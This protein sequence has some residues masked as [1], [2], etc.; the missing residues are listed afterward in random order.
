MNCLIYNV[1]CD[2]SMSWSSQHKTARRK[3]D[4]AS[5]LTPP[6]TTSAESRSFVEIENNGDQGNPSTPEQS[7]PARSTFGN[8]RI[9]STIKS[10]HLPH[11]IP[12]HLDCQQSNR[13]VT[14]EDVAG[15]NVP[16]SNPEGLVSVDL[17]TGDA[18]D[19]GSVIFARAIHP[20]YS[21]GQ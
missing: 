5:E 4:S 7:S 6:T 2:Y 3:T 1:R 13:V 17:N 19:L 18:N 8:E 11:P 15:R 12:E 20:R 21:A 9:H 10:N 14:D 16:D